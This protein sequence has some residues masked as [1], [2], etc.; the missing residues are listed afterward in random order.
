[1]RTL[2]LSA[3][4]AAGV[5]VAAPAFAQGVYF[6]G[7]GVSVGVGRPHYDGPRHYRS[8]DY[9]RPRH[10]SYYRD[11]YRSYAGCRTVTIQR[12][13]GSVRRIRRCG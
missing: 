11:G 7:P 12:D 10:R 6:Q 3:V 1:M 8:Y 9:D 13:D 2:L 5:L 4:A